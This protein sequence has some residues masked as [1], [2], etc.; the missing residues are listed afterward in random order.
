[1]MNTSYIIIGNGFSIDLI[2]K[3]TNENVREKINLKNLFFMG[4]QVIWPKSKEKGFLS[5]KHCP[6]LWTLGARPTLSDSEAAEVITEIITCMNV[7]NLVKSKESYIALKEDSNIYIQ[8]YNELCTYLKNLFIYYNE[9]IND[10]DDFKPIIENVKLIS[11]IKKELDVGNKII[12]VTYNYDIFLER[13]LAIADIPFLIEGVNR[14]S[15]INKVRIIK[16]HGSISFSIP[17]TYY[18]YNIKDISD[19][20]SREM[21]EIKVDYTPRD[22]KSSLCAIIPPAGDSGRVISGWS[23]TLRDKLDGYIKKSTEKDSLL[24]YGLSY[25]HVDRMEI[26]NIISQINPNVRVTYVNPFPSKTLDAVLSSVFE[27]YYQI[28]KL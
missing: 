6:N 17:T 1:M 4:D 23:K 22:D 24:I 28:K 21:K 11:Y 8:A 5:R 2:S 15:K 27:N 13:L 26:D 12:V 3:I 16:P 20:I 10:N 14:K 25:N 19:S 9:Q 7:Y 18:S